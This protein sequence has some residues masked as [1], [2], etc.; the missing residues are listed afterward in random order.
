M[1]P[2][3]EVTDAVGEAP[4]AAARL[5][6]KRAELQRTEADLAAAER[7]YDAAETVRL[8]ATVAALRSMIIQLEAH[9]AVEREV[10]G[11]AAAIQRIKGLRSAV[12]SCL[13][14][15]GRRR[16]EVYVA[17]AAVGTAIEA[18]NQMAAQI[19]DYH[20]E[21]NALAD[22]FD[23]PPV[24]LRN[25]RSPDAEM[26]APAFPLFWRFAPSIAA[27][28]FDEHRMRERRTYAEVAES[29]AFR[30]IANAGGPKP[31]PPLTAEQE[32]EVAERERDKVAERAAMAEFARERAQM[33]LVDGVPEVRSF[34]GR[35]DAPQPPTLAEE[36]GE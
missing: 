13:N 6:A 14:D 4:S 36:I 27:T 16:D 12:G 1:A 11:K 30:I 23:L 32:A 10:E 17:Y 29:E 20:A 21:A 9:A 8:Q 31:F 19:R 3:K 25:P 7:R 2:S 34:G 24:S 15:Y 33:A 26:D 5:K 22:R 35:L 28:E 18:L